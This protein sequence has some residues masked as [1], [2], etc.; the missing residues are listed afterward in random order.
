MKITIELNNEETQRL[1]DALKDGL[2]ADPSFIKVI[3]N[4]L[5][6][7]LPDAT[8]SYKFPG[9][10]LGESPELSKWY[11]ENMKFPI[12]LA[13]TIARSRIYPS[14]LLEM[15]LVNK[16]DIKLIRGVDKTYSKQIIAAFESMGI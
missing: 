5:S 13:N 15:Y 6:G 4:Q 2:L 16:D 10:E 11:I 9:N 3:L 1:L 7:N 12:K 14:R 8:Y